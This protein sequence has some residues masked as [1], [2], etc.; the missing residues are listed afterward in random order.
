MTSAY[1]DRIFSNEYEAWINIFIC[2]RFFFYCQGQQ[3]PRIKIALVYG[4]Q[5]KLAF[6]DDLMHLSFCSVFSTTMF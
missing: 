3:S 6:S 5:V 2:A 1:S 4:N